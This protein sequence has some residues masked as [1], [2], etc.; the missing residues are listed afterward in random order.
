MSLSVLLR[1]GAAAALRLRRLSLPLRPRRVRF[2]LRLRR[3]SSRRR[4]RGRDHLRLWPLFSCAADVAAL[5]SVGAAP[6]CACEEQH[7]PSAQRRACAG[8]HHT[9]LLADAAASGRQKRREQRARRGS[10]TQHEARAFQGA[11]FRHLSA[12]RR[13]Q[14]RHGGVLCR[15][16]HV[17]DL[18][19]RRL[20]LPAPALRYRARRTR[21]R[22]AK[23]TA[24]GRTRVAAP[25][26]ILVAAAASS[27][28]GTRLSPRGSCAEP[29]TAQGVRRQPL[30]PAAPPPAGAPPLG[31]AGCICGTAATARA[32]VDLATK[33]AS[34][35]SLRARPCF[36]RAALWRAVA[37]L[38][39]ATGSGGAFE[40][41]LSSQDY[42]RPQIFS[43]VNVRARRV[44]FGLSC[45]APCAAPAPLFVPAPPYRLPAPLCTMMDVFRRCR[46]ACCSRCQP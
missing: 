16:A 14:Q 38:R 46:R 6:G 44:T 26:P 29:S 32:G 41:W 2:A 30:P 25:R 34:A 42:T 18:R 5:Q 31:A 45:Y 19:K 39:A 23:A 43:P 37:Q 21:A 15:D 36:R 17:C 33:E 4:R 22:R 24:A 27:S 10:G 35:R 7:V 1:L 28:I 8:L 11:R 9:Q 3:R 20:S 40:K 12:S 13:R